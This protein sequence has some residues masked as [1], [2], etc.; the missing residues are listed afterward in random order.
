MEKV[1]RCG[2]PRSNTE[3]LKTTMAA[4]VALEI[5][6]EKIPITDASEAGTSHNITIYG[7]LK[8]LNLTFDICASVIEQT[9][10]KQYKREK[11]MLLAAFKVS[12]ETDASF[13]AVYREIR[14]SMVNYISV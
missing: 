2:R 12:L 14:A 6:G 9:R 11:A 7:L 4:C 3:L 13:D 1:S 8:G 10:L 5:I